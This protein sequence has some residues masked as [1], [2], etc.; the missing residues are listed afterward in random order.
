MKRILCLALAVL[1]LLS[2]ASCAAGGESVEVWRAVSPYYLE[3]GS[4]VRSETVRVDAGL[5]AIDAAVEA[6]NTGTDRPELRRALPEGVDVLGWT[7][8][9]GALTLA[10]SPGYAS[11]AGRARTVA[12][13]CITLTF[14]AIEGVES[15]SVHALGAALSSSMT[16]DGFVLEPQAA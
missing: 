9:G 5:S 11:L 3:G 6:F 13:C 1:A 7:L 8:D 4:A 12:D 14:C 2:L 10:V 16:P 15:V